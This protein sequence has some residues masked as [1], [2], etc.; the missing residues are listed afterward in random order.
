MRT[1]KYLLLFLVLFSSAFY[2][3]AY[4]AGRKQTYLDIDY[5]FKLYGQTRRYNMHIQ[6]SKDGVRIDWTIFSYQKWLKGSYFISPKGLSQGNGLNFKQPVDG[7]QEKLKDNE[8]FGLISIQALKSLK[9]KGL[10]IYN[11]TT[12]KFQEKQKL[13]VEDNEFEALYVI[14]DVDNTK[15]WIWDNQK[16]PLILKIEENPLEINFYIEKFSVKK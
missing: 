15:M 12:Y 6:E 14:A 9:E 2:V 5:V 4:E 7:M 3:S 1:I 11:N 10:F 8:T 13:I 16:L